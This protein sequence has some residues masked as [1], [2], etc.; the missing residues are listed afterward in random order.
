MLPGS[1]R[2]SFI[3]CSPSWRRLRISTIPKSALKAFC[4]DIGQEKT[5]RM[6]S[7]NGTND[8][9]KNRDPGDDLEVRRTTHMVKCWHCGEKFDLVGAVWCGCGKHVATAS[10]LCPYC[11]QCICFHPN[12]G[13]DEC[14]G[15]PPRFLKERGFDR[16]FYMYL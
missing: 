6:D 5:K 16:L 10:K 14:W 7:S 13:N 12:Y 9:N 11:F 15:E 2:L 1:I 3:A 4:L 8:R